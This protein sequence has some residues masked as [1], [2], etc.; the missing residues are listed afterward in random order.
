MISLAEGVVPPDLGRIEADLQALLEHLGTAR[1]LSVHLTTD[2]EIATLN[3]SYRGK[4]GPTDVLSFPQE[5]PLLGDVVVSL[6]TARRQA[7]ERGHSDAVELRV[8]LVHGLAHLLGHDHHAADETRA[9][10]AVER[11]LLEVIG[12][13]VAGLVEHAHR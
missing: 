4:S 3:E 2:A 9:M 11:Q 13:D 10:R 7:A 5:A 1:E 6:D 12:I 8:L